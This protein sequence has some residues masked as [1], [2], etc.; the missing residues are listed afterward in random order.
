M[1][2]FKKF[3][4]RNDLWRGAILNTIAHA[5]WIT[6]RPLL[7]Y[8]L[9]W[10][11]SN[12]SR[13]DTMGTHGTVS[14]YEDSVVGVFFD[15]HSPRNPFKSKKKYD[16]QVF[17][18]GMPSEL[19]MRAEQEALQYV[20]EEYEGKIQPVITAAFWSKGEH[21]TAAEP[22][23]NVVTHGAHLIRIE[24]TQTEKAFREIQTQYEFSDEQIQLVRSIYERK[25]EMPNAN[26][27]LTERERDQIS[28]QGVQG[29]E[30]CREL[31]SK[32]GITLP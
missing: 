31:F 10:D 1:N 4:R 25:V 15:L 11:G 18:K 21:L 14:F 2:I 5:I 9:S 8:E 27:L 22:W 23:A 19:L 20:L 28:S 26:L 3:P 30:Q 32:I 13:Q 29:L 6:S 12:Y 17:E 16:I 24:V 7:A